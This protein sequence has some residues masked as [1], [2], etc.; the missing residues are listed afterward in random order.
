MA[1]FETNKCVLWLIYLAF[2]WCWSGNQWAGPE[3]RTSANVGPFG[4]LAV[5]LPFFIPLSESLWQPDK[6]AERRREAPVSTVVLSD[7][8]ACCVRVGRSR[9]EK[10][11]GKDEGAWAESCTA[12]W[13][14]PWPGALWTP[15]E[16]LPRLVWNSLTWSGRW[17]VFCFQKHQRENIGKSLDFHSWKVVRCKEFPKRN[18]IFPM[19]VSLEDDPHLHTHTPHMYTH[20]HTHSHTRIY[21][22]QHFIT[23]LSCFIFSIALKIF[24]V[25][26]LCNVCLPLLENI[27]SMRARTLLF[28]AAGPVD[29]RVTGT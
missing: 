23:P 4:M 15:P 19:A 17:F 16:P 20:S 28:I 26:Y 5:P 10:R 24:G 22:H 11:Q 12:A 6:A 13:Y 7:W 1:F 21:V 3:A 29:K 9:G 25:T 2:I 18:Y 27:N 8:I 14:V